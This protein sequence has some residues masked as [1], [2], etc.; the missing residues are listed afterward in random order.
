MRLSLPR[1]RTLRLLLLNLLT[2]VLPPLWGME[3]DFFL[4]TPIFKVHIWMCLVFIHIG[5]I[6]RCFFSAV[7]LPVWSYCVINV[8]MFDGRERRAGRLLQICLSFFSEIQRALLL[9]YTKGLQ[10][11]KSLV[12]FMFLFC[13]FFCTLSDLNLSWHKHE[14]KYSLHRIFADYISFSYPSWSFCITVIYV[15]KLENILFSVNC[16]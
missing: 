14:K 7:I 12:G 6:C 16:F 10:S 2:C 13:L 4:L 15:H 1:C 11:V 5:G 3:M 8:A 9:C